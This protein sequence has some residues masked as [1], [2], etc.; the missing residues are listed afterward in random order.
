MKTKTKS[1]FIYIY[2]AREWER[3]GNSQIVKFLVYYYVEL[4]LSSMAKTIWE[5]S[6][7]HS[8]TQC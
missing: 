3:D 8:Q 1:D 2:K 6:L 7:S 4:N 5:S